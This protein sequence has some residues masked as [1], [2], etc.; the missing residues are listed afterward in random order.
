MSAG[1]KLAVA[2]LIEQWLEEM[3]VFLVDKRDAARGPS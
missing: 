2:T 1:D 3:V